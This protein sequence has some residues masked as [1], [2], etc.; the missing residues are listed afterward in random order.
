MPH[1]IDNDQD[2]LG[3]VITFSGDVNGI[4]IYNLNEELVSNEL[5]IRWRYQIWDFSDVQKFEVA[6]PELRN[7]ARQDAKAAKTNSDQRI[8]ILPRKVGRGS[9]DRIF[10]IYEKVWGAYESQTFSDLDSARVWGMS[11]R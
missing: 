4:E 3:V 5:F 10:H 8:A 6:F 7:F 9:T 2:G 1:I 11:D